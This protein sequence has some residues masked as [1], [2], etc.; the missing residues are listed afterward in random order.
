L[1]ENNRAKPKF[2]LFSLRLRHV[3]MGWILF[4]ASC[5]Y[6]VNISSYPDGGSL[7][8]NLWILHGNN[9]RE[10]CPDRDFPKSVLHTLQPTTFD[11]KEY[12]FTAAICLV[13]SDAEPYFQ[14]W[15]DYHLI[16]MN[17]DNIYVYDNSE[18]FEL[19]RWY[20][21]TR[22]HPKY[23]RVVIHHR[24][25]EGSDDGQGRYLQAGV[26][27][28]CISQYGKSQRGPQHSYL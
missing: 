8:W 16:A 2:N 13:V 9:R 1:A 23:G 12:N 22:Q 7:N 28:D 24:P 27:E 4:V 10:G 5:W 25:G 6:L 14:E 17:F 18:M 20:G 19:A 26:Y 21:N 11:R 15:V 3:M